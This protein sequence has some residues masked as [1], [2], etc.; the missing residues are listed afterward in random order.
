MANLYQKRDRLMR[1]GKITPCEVDVIKSH[2]A[3][4]GQLDLDDVKFMVELLSD[5][6]EVCGEFDELFFPVVRR[7]LLEDEMV[8][9][10][11][12]FMLLKMLYSDGKVRESEKRFL[13]DLY[14]ESKAV[15]PEFHQMCETALNCPEE[16]WDLGG[17]RM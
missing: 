9:F 12:Q 6:K 7:V 5:A 17:S 11:E 4:D 10:D 16:N 15:S 14:R 13:T 3:A 8:T 1:D 2:M